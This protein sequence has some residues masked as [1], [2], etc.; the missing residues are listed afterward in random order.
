MESKSIRI[1]LS[2]KKA[3]KH[4]GFFAT[5]DEVDYD[6]VKN[7]NWNV[8]K[9]QNTF[10]AQCKMINPITGRHTVCQMHRMI[11]GL[12]DR[13]ILV[14]HKDGDG[15]NNQRNNI[16]PCTNA[17]NQKNKRAIGKSK[18]LGVSLHIFKRRYTTKK[19][20][21]VEKTYVGKWLSAIVIDGK[22]KHL[23][24][25]ETEIEAAIAYD[26]AAIANH[27]QFAKPNFSQEKISA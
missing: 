18:Y 4:I 23:G 21:R 3:T 19:G 15:L 16:R 12:T 25:F 20:V 9:G 6:L 27:G 22:R 1:P 17:E 7:Y 13:K 24:C 2:G 26:K 8:A 11:L 10:Y 14:D 5:I